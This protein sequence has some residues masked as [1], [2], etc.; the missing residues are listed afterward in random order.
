MYLKNLTALGFKSFADKTSLDFQPGV[1]A[2]VGPNGCGKSNVS[3][4]LR[5]VLGEQS[6]KALRGSGM[7]DVIFNGTDKRKALSMAEVS[8]TI[9]GIDSEQLKT[10]GVDLPYNEVTVTR[11][12]FRD[13]GSEYFINKV[14][15][16][17]RD[18][19]QLF[20]GTGMGRAS[21]GI[22]AQGNITQLIS[23][24]PDDRRVV[25]EEAAGITRFKQQKREALRKLDY[26][27]QNLLRV[28]DTIREV[29]RQI[30][31]LQ[32]QAAKA[33]RYK[34]FMGELQGLESQLARHQL[35]DL[36]NKVQLSEKAIA[37]FKDKSDDYTETIASGERQINEARQQRAAIEKQVAEAQEKGANLQAE[38]ERLESRIQFSRERIGELDDQVAKAHE[39]IAE[40]EQRRS[41]SEAEL[42]E[43]TNKLGTADN[44]VADKQRAVEEKQAACKAIEA[45]LG[46]RQEAL[47]QA[48][49]ES[50][51][52][53]QELTRVRNELN[54][55]DLQKR[56]NTV[57][58]EKLSAEKIQLEEEQAKL[59]ERLGQ[60]S[61]EVASRKSNAQNRRG[62]VEE[63]QQRLTELQERLA[64]LTAELDDLLR[65]Q[66][67]KRSRLNVLKQLQASNEGVSAGAQAALKESEAALGLLA[68]QIRVPEALVGA[69]EAALGRH[70]QLVVTKQATQ[71]KAILQS[72]SEGKKGRADIV[73]L[74]LL[75]GGETPSIDEAKLKEFGGVAALGQVGCDADV[76]PLL[77]RLLGRLVIVPDLDAAIRGRAAHRDLDFVTRAGE[78][79]SR[80]GVFSGGRGNGSASASLL[81]RKNEI[82]DLEKELEAL[83]ETVNKHS[84]EKGDLQAEQTTLQAGLQE[85]Q[86]ELRQQEV[87]I[88]TS[89]GELK[90]LENSQRVLVQKIEAVTFELDSLAGQESEGGGK[91]DQ[92]AAELVSLE[93]KERTSGKSVDEV[94]TVV[95]GLRGKRDEAN[96]EL[97]E[98]KVGLAS[99]EQLLASFKRQLDPLRVRIDELKQRVAQRR[100]DIEAA[101][102]KKTQTESEISTSTQRIEAVKVEREQSS[103]AITGLLE[104]KMAADQKVEEREDSLRSVRAELSESQE[105]R[106]QLEV[107]LAQNNMMVENLCERMEA[108][109]QIDL[110]EVEVQYLKT[111]ETDSGE[112]KIAEATLEEMETEGLETDWE[113][114]EDKVAELQDRVDRMGPVNLVAIEEYEE[115]E[116]RY[117]FLTTQHDDL[118]KAKEQLLEVIEQINTETTEMF[119]ATFEQI[120]DNFRTLF[121]EVFEGGKADLVLVDEEDVLSSGI[122]IVAR[123]PGKKLQSISLLSGGEQTM[124][125]VSLMFSI[126]QVSP[127]PF[128]VL[129]ELDAPLDESNINRFI[130][131]L[132]RFINHSQFLVITHNKRTISMADTL[133]GV[134]MQE[135]GVSKIVSA[136]FQKTERDEDATGARETKPPTNRGQAAEP[137]EVAAESAPSDDDWDDDGGGD[138]VIAMGK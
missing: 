10:A 88:A 119:K 30:G 3:D 12:I 112:V 34:E 130:R 104:Q 118:V 18:I 116:E 73:A 21:Y 95:E 50:F 46:Q 92:L 134:T 136:R 126:Y 58:L 64:K 111:T 47:R 108:K 84:R 27:E 16:R 6:A 65:T 133:Y 40:A 2:I 90:A 41:D 52:V 132:K 114:V 49:T 51:S 72:L 105:R 28:S 9:G 24:K 129:D 53:A 122:E 39:E 131:V 138:D 93:E 68:D 71:A 115:T 60:F 79:L 98:A 8:L 45:E 91:R 124:T 61:S 11:R 37:E 36:Q 78:L 127:S 38:L 69:V 117:E 101:G 135:H 33:K 31:S 82:A 23:S 63:R 110:R 44:A 125:A 86:N 85:D 81:A 13:G 120:R 43:M 56:G 42:T 62:T 100:A 48:Q 35:G 76:Q 14:S 96:T 113:S 70:L 77:D 99:E 89:E 83:G 80:H 17:L 22:M 109:Y 121:T 123:P 59:Q 19:Q 7:A 94:G 87:A 75:S 26:T 25:F 15:C 66:A 1:T 54:A 102:E 55:L 103:Q 4:A 5:W 97:T 128:C 32:R 107:E 106:S 137:A 57:R 29:K 20:M 74:D 67:E